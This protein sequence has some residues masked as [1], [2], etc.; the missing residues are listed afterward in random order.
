MLC[1]VSWGGCV[2]SGIALET[3]EITDEGP[4]GLEE[5]SILVQY[6]ASSG[7]QGRQERVLQIVS[8]LVAAA[9]KS[10]SSN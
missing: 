5:G 6:V 4:G 1:F 7:K 10:C 8:W 9:T 3:I 2:E